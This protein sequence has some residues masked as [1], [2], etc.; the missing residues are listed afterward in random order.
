MFRALLAHLQDSLHKNQLVYCVRITSAGTP[1]LVAASRH[2]TLNIS[3]IY[4]APPEDE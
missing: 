1:A 2:N 4:A 3:N